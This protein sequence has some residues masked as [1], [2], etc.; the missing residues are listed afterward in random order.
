MTH[1]IKLQEESGL[2]YDIPSKTYKKVPGQESFI[3]LAIFRTTLSGKMQAPTC[4]TSV[5]AF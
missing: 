2:Y 3:L 1:F 5:T 4:T